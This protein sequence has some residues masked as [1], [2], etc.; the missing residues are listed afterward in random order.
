TMGD[1]KRLAEGEFVMAMGAPWGLSRSV[2]I[3]IISCVDRYLDEASEYSLWLQTDASISPGNSGGPLV[4]TD[5]EVIGL[6]ARGSMQ[7]GDMGFA[8]PSATLKTVVP[9]LRDEGQVP[10]LYSG[11]KLQPLRDFN[12][13]MYF[14]GDAGVVI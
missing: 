8:I 12:R 7:G 1:S 9:H 10:W 3:G 14:D 13:D 2:S 4:N 6:N 5:G 11:L